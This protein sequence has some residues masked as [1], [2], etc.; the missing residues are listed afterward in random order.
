MAQPTPQEPSAVSR[1]SVPVLAKDPGRHYVYLASD[2]RGRLLYIGVTTDVFRRMGNHAD[3]AP[4]YPNLAHLEVEEHAS[5]DEALRREAH[6]IRRFAPKHNTLHTRSA[7][8]YAR[9]RQVADA[10]RNRVPELLP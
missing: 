8:A 9:M 6:L 7:V 10:K 2:S 1:T 5:R 3:R 4:W